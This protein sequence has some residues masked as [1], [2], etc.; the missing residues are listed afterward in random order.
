MT[1]KHIGRGV[2]VINDLCLTSYGA[3]EV[4]FAVVEVSEIRVNM[5]DKFQVD[6]TVEA[7]LV[8]IDNNGEYLDSKH[9]DL[10][11]LIPIV[12]NPILTVG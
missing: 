5:V 12:S 6:T 4:P 9:H 10:L 8:V 11:N 3:T 1:P 7:S 2:I